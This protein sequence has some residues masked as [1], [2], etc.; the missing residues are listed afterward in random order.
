M[1]I[2]R[3]IGLSRQP[4]GDIS[5]R[6]PVEKLGMRWGR[7]VKAEVAGRRHDSPAEMVLPDP[8]DHHPRRQRIGRIG[9]PPRQGRAALGL[10]ASGIK[11]QCLAE[12]AATAAGP[13]L[14]PFLVGSPRT[15]K[16]VGPG[17]LNV[18]AYTLIVAPSCDS[19]S[20][21]SALPSRQLGAHGPLG[22]ASGS[23]GRSCRCLGSY[24]RDR[25][26]RRRPA[27]GPAR[28]PPRGNTRSPGG[29][30]RPARDRGPRR[31]GRSSRAPARR[32]DRSLPRY[33]RDPAP[34]VANRPSFR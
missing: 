12:T 2:S 3:W 8:V 21:S 29:R 28:A 14:R 17:W 24:G 9:D 18:P 10:V 20:R 13:H 19:R 1:T 25:A 11:A 5:R 6:Q 26:T 31:R 30:G 22:R 27:T 34:A 23:T 33:S 32:R 16:W 15:S 7:A 4:P